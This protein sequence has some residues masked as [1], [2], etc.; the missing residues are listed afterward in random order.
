MAS[1]LPTFC[2]VQFLSLLLHTISNSSPL[3]AAP[4]AC[5]FLHCQSLLCN[6][7][8]II[9]TDSWIEESLRGTLLFGQPHQLFF[10]VFL[11]P[12]TRE[13]HGVVLTAAFCYPLPSLL[14]WGEVLL[15]ASANGWWQPLSKMGTCI[16]SFVLRLSLESAT[17]PLKKILL[18]HW[19][20]RSQGLRRFL[21]WF[22]IAIKLVFFKKIKKK[23]PNLK[24]SVPQKCE[25][26]QYGFVP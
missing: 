10:Q 18:P 2:H 26:T 20:T 25:G 24:K 12:Q 16:S 17:F 6:K 7:T 15:A 21:V 4:T 14:L 11:Q 9:F 23:I 22:Y 19:D 1:Y 5:S 8:C 13:A 3:A